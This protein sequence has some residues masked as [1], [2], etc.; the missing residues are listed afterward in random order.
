MPDERVLVTV[1][2]RFVTQGDADQL[3]DRIRE[4]VAQIVGREAL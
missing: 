4:S 3:G 2:I 1:E